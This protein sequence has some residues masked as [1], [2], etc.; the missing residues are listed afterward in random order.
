M[1][2]LFTPKRLKHVL[3]S[4]IPFAII[5]CVLYFAIWIVTVITPVILVE[6][7]YQYKRVLHD[8][9][10]V[11]SIKGLLIPTIRISIEEKSKNEGGGI[12]IPALY[13]DEP[14]VYN[15][16]PNNEAAYKAALTRGIAHASSTALPGNGG[17]GYYFAHSS[18]PGLW[19]QY[20]AVFYLLGKLKQGDSIKLWH[21]KK[22]YEYAVTQTVITEPSNVSF[23][24][25]I[26][27]KETIV[28]Q[29]CWPP[30]TTLKRLLVFAE[31]I[32]E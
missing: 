2:A 8:M 32:E 30:G 13:L 23:L 6:T 15:V 29:T 14:V 4:L 22:V 19:R 10:H 11:T 16:D 12:V 28:L 31:R 9:F 18:S 27:D 20:N 24:H 7:T 17:L 21:E 3:V 26:Y 5:G 1:T 25:R